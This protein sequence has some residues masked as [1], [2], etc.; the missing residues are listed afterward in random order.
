MMHRVVG[1]QSGSKILS[2]AGLRRNQ[3]GKRC[4]KKR[5]GILVQQETVVCLE[6]SDPQYL[7]A[8]RLELLL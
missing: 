2:Q 4:A 1:T 6:D 7:E 3:L 5:A 8:L